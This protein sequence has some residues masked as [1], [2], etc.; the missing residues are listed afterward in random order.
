M[1]RGRNAGKKDV[2]IAISLYRHSHTEIIEREEAL[3]MKGMIHHRDCRSIVFFIIVFCFCFFHALVY[4]QKDVRYIFTD[5]TQEANLTSFQYP[6]SYAVWVDYDND[7]DLDVFATSSSAQNALFENL[8]DGRFIN[9]IKGS[10]IEESGHVFK[11]SA[12]ADIDNDGDKDLFIPFV[13]EYARKPLYLNQGDGRFVN[14]NPG[15]GLEY[16]GIMLDAAWF[17]YNGD[18][19][20]DLICTTGAYDT[21]HLFQNVGNY[22]FRMVTEQ[23]ILADTWFI[24]PRGVAVA[25]YDLDGDTDF[26]VSGLYDWSNVYINSGHGTFTAADWDVGVVDSANASTVSWGDYNNDGYPDLFVANFGWE[27]TGWRNSLFQ[28]NKDGTFSSV[29][30]QAGLEETWDA[31]LQGIWVDFNNDGYLDLHVID[32]NPD[33]RGLPVHHLFKNNWDGTFTDV[34]EES[35]LR[36]EPL[37]PYATWGDYD[38]DGDV[39][40]L[41]GALHDDPTTNRL[42]R[43]DTEEQWLGLR[44]LAG[45]ASG[46]TIGTK[47]K[48]YAGDM[49]VARELTAGSVRVPNVDSHVQIGLNTAVLVDS[50]EILWPSGVRDSRK[51]VSSNQYVV[52]REGEG[53]FTGISS[54]NLKPRRFCLYPNIPNPFNPS[55]VIRYEITRPCRIKLAVYDA[56][57]REVAVLKEGY[58][59]PGLHRIPWDAKD[60]ASGIYVLRIEADG[61]VESRKMMLMR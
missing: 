47:V 10:G 17:D 20:L 52:V 23:A 34:M 50:V 18:R 42:F 38:G 46:N 5:V 14:L 6:I 15:S 27:G 51:D 24:C 58:A 28:N 41:F 1:H 56:L 49:T 13:E 37:G 55:T 19:L 44:L 32:R 3:T 22:H 30:Q 8:G 7:A 4:G 16:W 59:V 39:D 21:L 12:W 9:T 43:N 25:D 31:T 40:V 26:Y 33:P 57:G 11:S 61:I 36:E 2:F 45:E 35:S 60:H 54:T 48:V 53:V 29:T